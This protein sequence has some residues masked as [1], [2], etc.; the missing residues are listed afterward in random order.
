MYICSNN[1]S[2][3]YVCKYVCLLSIE[4]CMYVGMLTNVVVSVVDYYDE[5]AKAYA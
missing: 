1:S 5:I 4:V 3:T 2:T